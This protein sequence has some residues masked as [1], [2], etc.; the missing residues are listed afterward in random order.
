VKSSMVNESEAL[1]ARAVT[2]PIYSTTA[3]PSVWLPPWWI[4]RQRA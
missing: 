1:R 4:V 2:A 3:G